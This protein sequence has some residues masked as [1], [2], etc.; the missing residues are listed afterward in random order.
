MF[1]ENVTPLL[2]LLVLTHAAAIAMIAAGRR[3][4][5]R[6][7]PRAERKWRTV[8]PSAVFSAG[9]APSKG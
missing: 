4:L 3:G 7:Q 8:S 9:G 2:I 5:R 1:G 6:A